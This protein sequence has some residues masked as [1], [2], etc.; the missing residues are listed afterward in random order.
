MSNG[1]VAL[2]AAIGIFS[3]AMMLSTQYSD[4]SLARL[5]LTSPSS[6]TCHGCHMV[7]QI[8]DRGSQS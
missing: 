5:H 2:D 3:G 7:F 1:D 4:P 6:S 8:R